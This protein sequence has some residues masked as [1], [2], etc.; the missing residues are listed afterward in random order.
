MGDV[1]GSVTFSA[2]GDI[3]GGDK[4]VN[5]TTTIQ[6][7]VEAVT[8][9]P[10]VT[11]SPYRGLERFEDR[12]RDLFFGR[13]QLI[14]SLLAQLSTSNVLLVLGAS[15]SGKSSVVRA[16]LLPA[17]SRLLGAKFRS[18]TLVP[19]VNPFESLRSSLYSAG[20]SQSQTRDLADAQPGAPSRLIHALQREG[21]QWLIFVDQFEEIFTRSEEHLRK[22]FIEAL[23]AIAQDTTSS[24]KLVLAMRADFLDRFSPFPQFAKLIERNI[25]LVADMHADEL[26]LAIEQ[27]A[28]RHGVVFEQGLVEEIIKDV[29]GQAGSLPLLQYTLDLLWEEELRPDGLADRHLNTRAYRELGGVRGALQKRADEIYAA[30][31]DN[32]DPKRASAKQEIV[33]QMFLRLVDIAGVASDDAVWRPVRRRAVMAIFTAAQEQELLQALINQKLLVSNREGTEATVEVAHEALFTSWER[34]KK[35]IEGGKQVI[36]VKN[37]LADDAR[38]W[39]RRQQEDRADAEEELL[40][41]SRLGQAL[42]MRVRGDF[43]TIF[44]GLSETEAE[45]LDA[46]DALRDRRRQEEQERQQRELEAAQKLAEAEGKRAEEQIQ[47]RRRQRYFIYGLVVLLLG[48]GAIAGI[49][50][51]QRL[52]AQS[53]GTKAEQQQ[54]IAFARQLAAQGALANTQQAD[55]LQQSVLL[56]LEAVSRF[57]SP[58]TEQGLRE[59]VALLPRLLFSFSGRGWITAIVISPD[60][61]QIAAIG[62]RTAQVREVASGRGIATLQHDDI[63]ESVAFSPNGGYVATGSSDRTARIWEVASGAEIARL[64]HDG[65]LNSV[66]FSPDGAFLATTMEVTADHS[67]YAYLWDATTGR[68]VVRVA[69]DDQRSITALRFAPDGRHFATASWDRTVRVWEA[70]TG[71]EVRRLIHAEAVN[72]IAYDKTG[73]ILVSGSEDGRVREWDMRTGNEIIALAMSHQGSVKAVSFSPDGRLL[74]TGGEDHTARVWDSKSGREISRMAHE[75]AVKAVIFSP[76]GKKIASTDY[77]QTARLWD[78]ATG[79]ETGRA[80]HEAT[81]NAVAFSP[82]GRFL[83]SGSG[84]TQ[85]KGGTSTL[86]DPVVRLWDLTAGQTISRYSHQGSIDDIAFSPDGRYLATASWDHTA[87]VSNPITGEERFRVVHNDRVVSL[88]ISRDSQWLATGSMDRNVRLLNLSNGQETTLSTAIGPVGAMSFSPDGKHLAMGAHD[89]I[90]RVWDITTQQEL[91]QLRHTG[92]VPYISYSADGL[93]LLTYSGNVV[94]LWNAADGKELRAIPF[95]SDVSQAEW[96]PDSQLVATQA[97]TGVQIWNAHDGA[98]LSLLKHE[99]DLLK[100]FAWHPDG[101]RILTWDNY[102]IRLWDVRA[103]SLIKEFTH[104]STSHAAFTPDGKN[105]VIISGD[106]TARIWEISTG[107]EVA[108][109]L[110]PSD[111]YNVSVSPNGRYIATLAGGDVVTVW[112][113]RSEDVIAE[114]HRRLTRNLTFEEWKRFFGDEPY[115]KTCPNLPIHLSVIDATLNLAREGNQNGFLS[116]AQRV[117][118][119]EPKIKGDVLRREGQRLAAIGT[120]ERAARRGEELIRAE[121]VDEGVRLLKKAQ[122]ALADAQKLGQTPEISVQLWNKIGWL[123]TVWGKTADFVYSCDQAVAADPSMLEV[124]DTRGVA[125]ALSGNVA[126]AI[127]DFEAFVSVSEAGEPKSRRLRWIQAL[128]KGDNPFTPKELEELRRE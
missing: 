15:G 99:G 112:L 128:K 122:T 25:D 32:A 113:W 26:R 34:L 118:A 51:K 39:H 4:I 20:F 102:V 8:Q 67:N 7:S 95:S 56:G 97:E 81:V 88:A 50:W 27:P 124:R 66:V 19:D 111:P 87:R 18:F 116:M 54:K 110:H 17:L 114:A 16:G 45:F 48:T 2:L 59:R 28:A 126:G 23:L 10:L 75:R 36:F 11:T 44:G 38:R 64:S 125:R 86:A 121:K 61:K 63:I 115:R 79:Q 6:I 37:R 70:A 40:S 57:P 33:R 103:G 109:L 22:S 29:Q 9:R 65:S 14:K 123:G 42:E 21:E 46:S 13:D 31:G 107:R 91:F 82:D 105:V 89:G 84:H 68:Q 108:G 55:L 94:R 5:T 90:A 52:A 12:D 83:A 72:A 58:E 24:T 93:Y 120:G 80:V 85:L 127:E 101:R 41:G 106:H 30:F 3:V 69:H 119:L 53:A 92:L 73:T 100:D 47:G 1:G 117:E 62:G 98:K 104:Q 49:A 71:R 78:A 74:A 43:G 96:S 76:D 35:W 60:G 77:T